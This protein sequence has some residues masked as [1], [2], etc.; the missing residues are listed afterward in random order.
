[1]ITTTDNLASLLAEGKI[2]QEEYHSYYP[3]DGLGYYSVFT[4]PTIDLSPI[5]YRNPYLVLIPPFN[6]ILHNALMPAGIKDYH[7]NNE[8]G[9]GFYIS[10]FSPSNT[11]C[12]FRRCLLS[13]LYFIL[14]IQGCAALTGQ[15]FMSSAVTDRDTPMTPAL[16]LPVFAHLHCL[17]RVLFPLSAPADSLSL[18]RVCPL[19]PY[20]PFPYRVW[21]GCW[22]N[23]MP[24]GK[25]LSPK[26]GRGRKR[27]WETCGC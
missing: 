1:M 8:R 18:V 2:T 14:N 3:Y 12:T 13:S 20:P 15:N 26:K 24:G 22:M 17:V 10:V 23:V 19:P 4:I 9:Y 16:F 21:R 27:R 25:P 11:K 6:R 7:I 5:L